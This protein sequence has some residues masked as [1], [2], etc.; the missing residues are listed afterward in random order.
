MKTIHHLSYGGVVKEDPNYYNIERWKEYE[1]D[2]RTS[3]IEFHHGPMIDFNLVDTSKTNIL[4]PHDCPNIFIHHTAHREK[5]EKIFDYILSPE[6]QCATGRNY[7]DC[8]VWSDYK[9]TLSLAEIDN[10]DNVE[11]DID[12]Y[13]TTSVDPDK[14]YNRISHFY[15]IAK[16]FNNEIVCRAIKNVSFQEKIRTNARSKISIVWGTQFW[17]TGSKKI[18]DSNIPWIKVIEMENGICETP[19]PKLRACEAAL[20]KSVM[21]CYKDKFSDMDHPFS[22]P[23]EDT[24]ERDVDFIYFE[25]DGK[26]LEEKINYILNNYDEFDKMR[27]SAYEKVM[28]YHD[29]EYFY[30][31]CILPIAKESNGKK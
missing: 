1:N 11:K 28:K 14:V 19:Q 9:N 16:K 3:N 29:I 23:I 10:I 15:D 27:D 7:R 30:N 6:N 26:D 18:A 24:F 5:C 4:Y 22:N 13:L 31:N 25:D 12:V 8:F 17:S 20:C 21:L 2:E